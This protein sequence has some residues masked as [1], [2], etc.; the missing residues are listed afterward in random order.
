M[1]RSLVMIL[2]ACAALFFAGSAYAADAR[3]SAD[4]IKKV[5]E[6]KLLKRDK[7][8]MPAALDGVKNVTPEDV[9]KLFDEKKTFVVLDNRPAEEYEKEHIPGA[10]RINSDDLLENSKLAAE[11][12]LKADDVIVCYCNGEMCW[13]SPAI[14]VMLQNLGYK[15]I[16]WLRSGLPGWVKKGYET[17]EGKK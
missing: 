14:A 13:R 1:K 8:E 4:T 10:I 2:A 11:A 17:A 5:D 6:F 12:G 16:N 3:Y 7:K 9:K 15:N